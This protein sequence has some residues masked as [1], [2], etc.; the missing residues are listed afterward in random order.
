MNKLGVLSGCLIHVLPPLLIAFF[1]YYI[2]SNV[3]TQTDAQ[4]ANTMESLSDNA[5][6]PE[7]PQNLSGFPSPSKYKH[8][9]IIY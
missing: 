5:P 2:S 6:P 9:L 3:E 8:A 7:S 1:K 4:D